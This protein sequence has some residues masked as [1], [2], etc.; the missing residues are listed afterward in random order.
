[1][2]LVDNK[3]KKDRKTKKLSEE[4]TEEP[5]DILV[6]TVIGF[7]EISTAYI[8]TVATQAFSLLSGSIKDTTID[9]ILAVSRFNFMLADIHFH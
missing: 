2:L 8:R 6:D 1:M 7:L 5:V 3:Q 9:L 4:V